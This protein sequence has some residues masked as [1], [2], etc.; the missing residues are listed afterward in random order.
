MP[1]PSAAPPTPGTALAR[2]EGPGRVNVIANV[3]G[4]GFDIVSSFLR[5][6]TYDEST[7]QVYDADGTPLGG[8]TA[9]SFSGEC[10]ADDVIV[11]GK[12]LI[13]TVL[14]KTVPA[15]GLTEE[16]HALQLDA[17]DAQTG[18][19]VWS[20]TV[21]KPSPEDLSCQAYDGNLQALST[22]F[23]GKWGVLLWPQPQKLL[24]LA[25]DLATGRLYPRAD[26]LGTIGNYVAVGTDKTVY[27][28]ESNTVRMTVPGSWKT[29]GT[30][31]SSGVTTGAIDLPQTGTM[32]WTGHAFAGDSGEKTVS[33]PSGEIIVS[34]VGNGPH[35]V[36]YSV[37]AF[38]LPSA[39]PL[40]RLKTPKY[41]NDNVQ[42]INDKIVLIVRAPNGGGKSVEYMAVDVTTGKKVW[43]LKVPELSTC[44]LTSSNVLVR[45]KDQFVTLDAATGKQLSYTGDADSCR[46]IVGAGLTGVGRTDD[47]VVQMLSP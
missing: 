32:A 39:K 18:A 38:Q 13:L 35:S 33:T 47:E 9:G 37:S 14:I 12:R 16:T 11:D 46:P 10:G 2:I 43:S 25:V 26:L 7:L 21:I 5:D 44:L 29:L 24:R 41:F 28:G 23:D 34:V 27:A 1:P 31:R 30:F 22:T 20:T 45:T 17:W 19:Q 40:W 36:P 6:F 8:L 42:S 4:R 3:Q 15:A